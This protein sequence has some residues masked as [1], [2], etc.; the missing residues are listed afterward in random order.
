[1][2]M[3]DFP[4]PGD[5][6]TL[7]PHI[8]AQFAILDAGMNEPTINDIAESYAGLK[9]WADTFI[10]AHK[11]GIPARMEQAREFVISIMRSLESVK[12]P[13]GDG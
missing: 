4:G 9:D 11:S 13:N 5:Y 7:P 8:R 12:I 10:Q 6:A 2:N 1:M 3:R